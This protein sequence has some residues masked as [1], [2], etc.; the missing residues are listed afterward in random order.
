[1]LNFDDI[2]V[3]RAHSSSRS[4]K[5]PYLKPFIIL[6]KGSL[7]GTVRVPIR[8]YAE[9]AWFKMS[10]PWLESQNTNMILI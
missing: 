6:Q 1:M 8:T 9:K 7:Q 10:G 4:T 3:T 2:Q 5:H